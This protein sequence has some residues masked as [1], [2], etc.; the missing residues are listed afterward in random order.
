VA[1]T[2][3]L[4]IASAIQSRGE[5]LRFLCSQPLT[6]LPTPGRLALTTPSPATPRAAPSEHG[7]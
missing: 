6:R 4:G 3:Q 7:E 5:T 2:L 1:Q